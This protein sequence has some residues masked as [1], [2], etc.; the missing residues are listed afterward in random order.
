MIFY[1]CATAP[2]PRRARMFIAEKGIEVDTCE[3]DLRHDGHRSPEFLALNPHGTVPV[4]VTDEGTALTEN[5]AIAGY[6]EAAFPEPTL[7]GVTPDEKG[8]VLMWNA[9]CEFHAGMAIAEALR[10]STP[11][12]K[13]RALPGAVDYEQIPALAA[14][15]VQRLGRF[16]D[17]L[18]ARLSESAYLA[19]DAFSMADITGFVFCDFARIVKQGIPDGNAA[20]KAWFETIKARHSATL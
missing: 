17:T 4:L 10:N 16:F 6:L 12:L 3:V 14:R 11:A 9:I 19:G 5:I 1:D 20:S 13:G 18:E 8:K 2:S 7:M 15:G